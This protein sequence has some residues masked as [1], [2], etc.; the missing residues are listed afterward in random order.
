[1]YDLAV[2]PLDIPPLCNKKRKTLA[3]TVHQE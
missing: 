2:S 1:M 3:Q